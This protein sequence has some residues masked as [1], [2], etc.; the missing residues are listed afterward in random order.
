MDGR[1]PTSR[2]R[3]IG[4]SKPIRCLPVGVALPPKQCDIGLSH[5]AAAAHAARQAGSR[6]G[7]H[8]KPVLVARFRATSLKLTVEFLGSAEPPVSDV[9]TKKSR[10]DPWNR[11]KSRLSEDEEYDAENH[12][13]CEQ[14]VSKFGC[15]RK[16]A[17]L[18]HHFILTPEPH[19]V[20]YTSGT[21]H[22]DYARSEVSYLRLRC[23]SAAG[24]LA[25]RCRGVRRCVARAP[26]SIVLR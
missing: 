22:P 15:R 5:H 24:L 11:C 4:I 20:S 10:A 1:P 19:D 13:N 7:R 3:R 26:L 17:L 14:R 21:V 9:C 23:R 25:L 6:R 18:D 16:R 8:R 2:R 12:E